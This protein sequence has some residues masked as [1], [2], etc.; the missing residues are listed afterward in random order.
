MRG[1]AVL[2]PNF[3]SPC[4]HLLQMIPPARERTID[5]LRHAL[6]LLLPN[7]RAELDVVARALGV[8]PRTFPY[9]WFLSPVMASR[10]VS[11]IDKRPISCNL[12]KVTGRRR[13]S[14]V[15]YARRHFLSAS[16]ALAACP[17]NLFAA[18][19]AGETGDVLSFEDA[20]GSVFNDGRKNNRAFVNAIRYLARRGGGRLLIPAKVYPFDGNALCSASNV[21]VVGHGAAFAGNGCRLTIDHG[22]RRFD[23]EGLS[24]LETSGAQG[25]YVF[26]CFGSNCRFT[27]VHLENT[28]PRDGAM[29]YCREGTFGN[30]FENF[31]FRGANGIF[32]AGHD[33]QVLG[34]WGDCHA[35]DDCWAIKAINEPTYNI[36][37]SGF[38]A[39]NFAS[40]LSIGS[41]VGSLQSDDPSRRIFVRNVIL[42]NCTAE[43]CTYLLYIKPGGVDRYDYRDGVVED[44]QVVNCRHNDPSGKHFKTT[45]AIKPARGA[46]VRR[47]SVKDVE[48]T[49]RG[50]IPVSQ[51]VGAVWMFIP[52][53]TNGAGA[54]SAIEDVSISGLRCRDPFGGVA[55]QGGAAGAPIATPVLIEKQNPE[56]GH[57]G[58]I[59]VIDSVFDG[60]ARKAVAI[61]PN[62]AGP[63][64]FVRCSFTNYA[65]A[66]LASVDKGSVVA[67]SPVRLTDI[68]AVPSPGGPADVRGV[69]P[70]AH[71]N[72][73]I[74]Y[75]GDV[76]RCPVANVEAG[77]PINY[78]IYV[79]DRDAWVSKV[80]LMTSNNVKQ[81]DSDFVRVSLRNSANGLLLATAATR[82]NGIVLQEQVTAAIN[83]AQQMSGV[84]S[85]LPR[86]A[87]LRVEISHQGGGAA[88]IEPTFLIHFVPYGS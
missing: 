36:R 70:D 28:T 53:L 39:R 6:L 58:A 10:D 16:A 7:G 25:M 79:A 8:R 83:G 44:V 77:R 41:Q 72:K 23:I 61:G 45:I 42:E 18:V 33:H 24:L 78:P 63:I 57:I 64:A 34:G 69:L 14:S 13:R 38:T 20:G 76:S 37:I 29:G 15:L 11:F 74:P 51:N 32:L 22:C 73:Q 49:A 9:W 84:A 21:T 56:I 67:H 27:D 68:V 12:R 88:L 62:L 65:A 47:V 59:E 2:R 55:N 60:A 86:G 52:A 82:V 17:T 54:G 48:V 19:L 87:E 35:S 3:R 40:V 81:S 1:K 31:S 4:T 30:L 43:A 71:P 66:P 5:H 26:D 85:Y 50:A 80:E 75:H 46:V